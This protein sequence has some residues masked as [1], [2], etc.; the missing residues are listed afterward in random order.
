MQQLKFL[1]TLENRRADRRLTVGE[2]D[3]NA[4]KQF[5]AYCGRTGRYYLLIDDGSHWHDYVLCNNC[6]DFVTR[7]LQ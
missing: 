1:I 3:D 6:S 7:G 4:E 5:C 2:L